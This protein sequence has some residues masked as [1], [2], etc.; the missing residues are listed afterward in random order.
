MGIKKI[1]NAILYMLYLFVAVA[2]IDIVVL[3][4][5]FKF[6][7]HTHYQQENYYRYPTPYTMFSG[8]PNVLDHNEF[9]F[10]GKSLKEA[11][12][13]TF[14]I[15]F[16]G[17]STGYLGDPPIASI[18][19]QEL[20]KALELDIHV[21]NFSVV[22]S[23]HRQ[24]L[25]AILEY[26]PG[27]EPDLIIFY[28]GYNET[29]HGATYDPRPGYPYNFFYRSELGDLRKLLI[30][31]S[32]LAGMF[33]I[34]TG[35]ISGLN[36][37]RNEQKPLSDEWNNAIVSKY[38]ETLELANR[39]THTIHSNRYGKSRFIAFYQPYQVPEQFMAHHQLIRDR[40]GSLEYAHDVS[41]RYDALGKSVYSDDVH[42]YQEARDAMGK[43]IAKF[44]L[45]EIQEMALIESVEP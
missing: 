1:S 45:K 5:I 14:K 34:K 30:R 10:R 37:L 25:H 9:G 41:S 29:V 35:L 2:F 7:Y 38:F 23:N 19:E 32:A 17:G 39:M 4:K 15:A 43:T 27:Y 36:D 28:G 6:G 3:K 13:Q 20:S 12:P 44:V 42:V 26:L 21:A 8:K 11:G 40:V 33:D 16:F 31:H 22:S 18:M 24:H